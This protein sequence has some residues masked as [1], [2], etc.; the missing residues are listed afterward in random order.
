MGAANVTDHTPAFSTGTFVTGDHTAGGVKF[1]VPTSCA[2]PADCG[3][4][5]VNTP[6][7]LTKL[8]VAF[9]S[10]VIVN[11]CPSVISGAPL[12]ETRTVTANDPNA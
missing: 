11:T 4:E 10:T 9:V 8:N 2:L 3:Q 7:A 1:V 12:S 5:S 6:P